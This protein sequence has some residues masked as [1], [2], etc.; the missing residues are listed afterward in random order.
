MA[1]D[2]VRPAMNSLAVRPSPGLRLIH[3]ADRFD[4]AF[5]HCSSRKS[6]DSAHLFYFRSQPENRVLDTMGWM[7]ESADLQPGA[8][9]AGTRLTEREYWDSV[10]E[11]TPTDPA[12]SGIPDQRR[13]MRRFIPA[14]VLRWGSES[15][16]QYWFWKDLLPR[17]VERTPGATVLEIGVAPGNEVLT[18]RECFGHEPLGLEYSPAGAEATRRNF[19]R[20]G[21]DPGNVIEGDLFEEAVIA[22]HESRFDVVFSRGF[23]E[24]FRD[25]RKDVA[26]HARLAKPGGLVIISIPTLTGIHYALTRIL[27]AHQI[28][29]HNRG[30]MRKEPF[31]R[32]FEGMGMEP[33]YCGYG[34]GLKLLDS[35]KPNPAGFRYAVQALALKLQFFANM[36]ARAGLC[37]GRYLYWSLVFIGRKR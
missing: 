2:R 13:G 33:L 14:A 19:E 18:F 9:K 31:R 26:Q 32:L 25:P 8:E 34:G 4:S 7:T 1:E 17:F 36:A 37:K 3:G 5:R 6:G 11:G 15:C 12:G 35:Y 30:I 28:A 29:I 10:H 27:M 20:H 24:H 16:G 23:I 21:V 22:R